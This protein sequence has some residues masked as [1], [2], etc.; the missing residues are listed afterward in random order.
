MAQ[1]QE[2]QQVLWVVNIA[3]GVFLL[4]LVAVRRNYRAFPA[5]SLYVLTN[6]TLS[7]SVFLTYKQWG[8]TSAAY[9]WSCWGMEVVVVCTRALAV[10]E[11]CR[12]LLARYRGIWGLVW[13]ALLAC[14]ALALIYS[15][16]AAKYQWALALIS[17]GRALELAIATVIVAVFVFVRYYGVE[18]APAD[19]SLLVGFCLYSCFRVLDNT[20]LE[21]YFYRNIMLFNIFVMLAFLVTQILWAWV[22]RK[23]LSEAVAEEALLPGEVYQT[24]APQINLRLRMLNEQLGQIWKSEVPRR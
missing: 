4:I 11:L 6:S 14:A 19:R 23:P 5:F 16:I 2:L 8:F 15:C 17:A 18:T 24:M 3:A 7:V 20:I 1:L 22:L 12:H 13:R 9:W 21:H 10:A